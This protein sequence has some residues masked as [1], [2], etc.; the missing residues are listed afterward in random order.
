MESQTMTL[1]VTLIGGMAIGFGVLYVLLKRSGG[2][3]GADQ[4]TQALF[5]EQLDAK[6]QL[7]QQM[8][9][10][11]QKD[12]QA[13]QSELRNLEQDRIKKFSEMS[14]VLE[15]HRRQTE[16]LQLSTR[17][18]ATVLSNNQ[19]R[20]EWGER[21]IED[22]LTS[23]GL[24]EGVH[25]VKQTKQSEGVLRPDITLL[26]PNKRV[27]PVDVKFPYAEIQKSLSAETKALKQQHLKQFAQDLKV[28]INKVAEYIDPTKDTLDYAILFVPNEMVFSYIN[29]EFPDVVD[30]AVSKR[31]LIVS[32]FTFL[33][34]ARTVMESYRNFM[35]G[36]KLNIVVKAVD[37]FAKEWLVFREKFEKH[38]KLLESLRSN[39]EEITG[40]RYR[41][42]DKKIN[43]VQKYRG[44]ALPNSQTTLEE[45][46]DQEDSEF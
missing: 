8:F 46:E 15:H 1:V 12:L 29:Q 44:A 3:T 16:E 19:A 24:V 37:E 34:V 25:Y 45:G 32:P 5:K 40:T 28:K 21:I 42:L 30:L 38:G 14:T 20:G 2:S 6:H 33:I 27:V 35:I 26:L 18:L 9:H 43:T 39:Y 22:L 11:L 10:Q 31:V 7:F 36:D 17:Q 13:S 4:A 23:N 41:Q